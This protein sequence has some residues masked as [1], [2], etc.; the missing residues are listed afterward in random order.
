M[1]A[2]MSEAFIRMQM[3]IGEEAVNRLKASGV[4]VFGVGGVGGYAV[5][6]LARAGIGRIVLIDHDVISDSNRN[7]QL[8]ALTTTIGRPKV[9]VIKERILLI[10]PE[11]EVITKQVFVLDDNIDELISPDLDYLVDALDTVTAKLA[12]AE[13]GYRNGIPVI[14][15]M[16]TGNKFDPTAFEVDDIYRTSVCP[17]CRV[18][19]RELKKRGVP[20]L[21]V[22]YS[23]EMPVTPDSSLLGQ[24]DPEKG[25]DHRKTRAVPGSMPFVPGA[26]GLIL[27]GE[28]IRHIA[29][30]FGT[31]E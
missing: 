5:E 3:L 13:Q 10:N 12:I 16:G 24:K 29:G 26:A 25:T 17:L 20:S 6:A 11:A 15:S 7:R 30:P 31:A 9:E 2:E 18:M 19:R 21:K 4:A 8:A 14:S 22:V 23:K 1:G 28:V 27:A